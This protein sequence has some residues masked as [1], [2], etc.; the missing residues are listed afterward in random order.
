MKVG[1]EKGE[2]REVSRG[3]E[4]TGRALRTRALEALDEGL[5]GHMHEPVEL[6]RR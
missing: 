3:F 6:V 1:L 2:R 5:S 4:A